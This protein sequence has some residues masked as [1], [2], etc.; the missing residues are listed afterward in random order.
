M[1]AG[2]T[3]VLGVSGGI[4]AYK[5]CDVARQLVHD[6]IAVHVIMTA[7]GREFVS[8]LTFQSLTANVVHTEL[9]NLVEESE[10]GHISLARRGDLMLVAPATADLIGKV[11][12]GLAD[13]LLTTAIMATTSPVL[14]APSM[15]P[16][17]WT[18]PILQSNVAKLK[19]LGYRFIEPGT[20][21]TAC[22]EEGQGR[23]ASV[24]AI[25]EAVR[26]LLVPKTLQG[27]R[28]LVTAGPTREYLDPVR[29]I[30]NRSSGKMGY[31]I[32]RAASM[33]GADV[34]VVSGPTALADPFD[35]EIVRVETGKE[36]LEAAKA[37]LDWSE[38]VVATAAVADF[39]PKTILKQKIRKEDIN[40]CI[41]IENT[42]D[43]LAQLAHDGKGRIFIGFAAETQGMKA[44][45][46]KKLKAKGIDLICA[47]D[48]SDR[49]IGFDSDDNSLKLIFKD[50]S[51][52][53]IERASKEEVAFNL[54]NVMARMFA[55]KA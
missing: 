46:A 19:G 24:E 14:F 3:V 20:G 8:P 47:N 30:S 5:V 36:M 13:D 37:W 16:A 32:A 54:C 43:I 35:V 27:R 49:S 15:N 29:F 22:G 4:A 51:T 1:F 23:L 7:A 9:F 33:C 48:V 55:K 40:D 50:G 31:A 12:S 26:T 28:I 38:M 17:M 10:I 53:D 42:E 52:E 44:K 11:A 18:N 41:L 2:K 34:R 25:L 39:R 6:G 45:A 21:I